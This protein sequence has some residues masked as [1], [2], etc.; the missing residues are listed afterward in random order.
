MKS[1]RVFYIML[2]VIL[3]CVP[4]P[5]FGQT[6]VV[7]D[8]TFLTSQWDLVFAGGQNASSASASRASGAGVTGDARI[9]NISGFAPM[10]YDVRHYFNNFNWTPPAL[11]MMT[12]VEFELW[13]K[14]DV[15]SSF[16]ITRI[17][18]RQGTTEYVAPS[19]YREPQNSSSFWQRHSGSFNASEF[20]RLSGPGPATLNFS[21]AVP[22]Q[23]WYQIFSNVNLPGSVR[24]QNSFFNL[25]IQRAPLTVTAPEPGTIALLA[26]GAG[27]LVF[28]KRGRVK[29]QEQ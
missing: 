16:S 18:A 6:V 29:T 24:V 10:Q 27:M 5:A 17:V 19:S 25:Q 14:F 22:I 3:S 28:L 11:G 4:F 7:H 21:S 20:T 23:V 8:Q 15:A 9:T 2:S 13:Y 1:A 26:I 12:A